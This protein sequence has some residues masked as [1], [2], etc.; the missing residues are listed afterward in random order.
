MKASVS[1]VAAR[2]IALL[3]TDGT[4]ILNRVMRLMVSRDLE[5]TV[6]E[7]LYAQARAKL[8]GRVDEFDQT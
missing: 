2:I 6:T 3:P 5:Q 4:P 8:L 7:D 1:T